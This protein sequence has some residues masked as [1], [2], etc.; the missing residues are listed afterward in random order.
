MDP[1]M[2]KYLEWVKSNHP[3]EYKKIAAL[4]LERA[5]CLERIVEIETELLKYAPESGPSL[6]LKKIPGN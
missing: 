1:V 4:W 5:I 3:N 6:T 2:P